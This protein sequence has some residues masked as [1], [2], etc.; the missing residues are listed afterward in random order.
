MKT[1]RPN[2][3]FSLASLVP[4]WQFHVCQITFLALP[5]SSDVN[6]SDCCVSV[7]LEFLLCLAFFPVSS[8]SFSGTLSSS[9]HGRYLWAS[10]VPGQRVS[11]EGAQG[12]LVPSLPDPSNPLQTC[13]FPVFTPALHMRGVGET[14]GQTT[15]GSFPCPMRVHH[16]FPALSSGGHWLLLACGP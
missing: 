9:N 12:H 16:Q 1:D 10:Q 6:H 11:E 13:L 2:V 5:A 4:H 7:V 8:V 14:T 15:I 3:F